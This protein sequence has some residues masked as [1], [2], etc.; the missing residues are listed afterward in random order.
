MKTQSV[1]VL[2]QSDAILHTHHFRFKKKKGVPCVAYLLS[3]VVT[4][5]DNDRIKPPIGHTAVRTT[6]ANTLHFYLPRLLQLHNYIHETC[7]IKSAKQTHVL[8]LPSIFTN[9]VLL[10]MH[11]SRQIV[12]ILSSFN[13]VLLFGPFCNGILILGNPPFS[14]TCSDSLEPSTSTYKGKK[15]QY[16]HDILTKPIHVKSLYT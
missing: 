8:L 7:I 14:V 15:T 5:F 6:G 13:T 12:Y 3:Q 2:F 9:M 10:I 11:L 4:A 16:H 1:E